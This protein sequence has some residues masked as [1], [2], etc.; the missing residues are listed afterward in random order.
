MD[1]S[2]PNSL[3]IDFWSPIGVRGSHQDGMMSGTMNTRRALSFCNSEKRVE[4][5]LSFRNSGKR[6]EMNKL[7]V[8]L[9]IRYSREKGKKEQAAGIDEAT[10]TARVG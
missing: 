9:A 1:K 7:P 8:K 2:A 4:R 10:D 6:V 5:A 3:K